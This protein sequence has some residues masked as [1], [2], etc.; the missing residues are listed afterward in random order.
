L[1]WDIAKHIN[2]CC[3]FNSIGA[4]YGFEIALRDIAIG[5]LFTDEYALFNDKEEMALHCHYPDYRGI[6]YL[7][8]ILIASTWSGIGR[9]ERRVSAW[10]RVAQHL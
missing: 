10:G 1:S 5:D 3:H 4:A 7:R 8:V 2:Q 9:S 6:F